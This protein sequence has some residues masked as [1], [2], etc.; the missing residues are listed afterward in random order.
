MSIQ[1]QY[2]PNRIHGYNLHHFG[3]VWAYTNLLL[4]LSEGSGQPVKVSIE[5]KKIKNTIL[6]ISPFLKS[7][8][9]IVFSNRRA[10]F[11]YNYC[12]PYIINFLPSIRTWK[13]KR[14]LKSKIVAYQF[15][16]NHLSEY[17][18]LPG[19]EIQFL[20]N[21]LKKMG[22]TPVNV[23][24]YKKIGFIVNTLSNCKFFVGCPSGL[25]VAA[26]SVKCPIN[27]I[28]WKLS[29]NDVGYLKYCQC[30]TAKFFERTDD[31]LS[32]TKTKQS[33]LINLL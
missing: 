16:G 30:P 18:N 2:D 4:R 10:N 15:D 33:R 7:S 29:K 25:S 20:I 23:G 14:S 17:K 32:F 24:G 31:F 26:R 8:G 5:N 21:Y 12:D 3:D 28:S 11:V 6:Q 9:T 19:N 13:Y 22:Y 1:N 27:L